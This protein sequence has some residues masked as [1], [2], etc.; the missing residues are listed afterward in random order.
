MNFNII[1]TNARSLRPKLSSFIDNFNELELSIAVVTETWFADGVRLDREA[2]DLLLGQNINLITRNRLIG[3]RGVAH[4]GVAVLGKASEVKLKELSFPNPEQF[5]VLPVQVTVANVEKKMFVIAVYIPPGYQV[6]RG[7]ACLQHINYLVLYIKNLPGDSNLCIAGDV[8]QWDIATALEDYPDLVEILTPPTRA[9]RNIDKIFTNWP[10]IK[11]T[12]MPPLET[13][14]LDGKKTKSDHLIQF[15]RAE[16]SRRE[17]HIWKKI[18]FRPFDKNSAANFKQDLATQ[19]WGRVFGAVGSNNKAR[20]FQTV[21]DVLMDTH[22]PKKTIRRKESDLPWFNEVAK[23]KAKRKK[24]VF[25]DEGKSERWI[26]LRDDLDGYLEGR[27]KKFLQ[28]QREG[29]TGGEASRQFFKLVKNYGTSEK[30]KTFDVRDLRP[31]KPDRDVA[32]EVAQYFNQISDEFSPLKPWEIPQTY[33]RDLPK[34]TPEMVEKR[35]HEMKKPNSM[36]EG[37]IFPKLVNECSGWLSVPLSD[38]YNCMLKTY[39]WP[40]AWKKEYVTVIPKKTLPTE[41]S[42]LRNISCTKFFSKVFESFLLQYAIEEVSTKDNQY[43]GKKG[44]STSHLLIE[45]WQNICENS[46]DYRAATA[47]AAI[48][49]SKAFNRLSFQ[50]CL[51]AFKRKGAS[52]TVIRLIA[53]FLTNRCMSVRVGDEWS[54]ELPVNGGCPQGSILGVFLFNMTTDDLEDDFLRAEDERLPEQDPTAPR[55]GGEG[56]EDINLPA[57]PLFLDESIQSTGQP[58]TSTPDREAPP[59]PE[60]DLSGIG[61][62]L[63]RHSDLIVHFNDYAKNIP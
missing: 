57:T 29:L 39:V 26:A 48:D 50:H 36:V 2:E 53:T 8:N 5:E 22:F 28:K 7:Q 16:L 1:N 32:D 63:Y 21:L 51:Q 17:P 3:P 35:L 27:Q 60:L 12:C 34:F 40:V 46:E 47:L 19:D 13:E 54:E 20:E 33:G 38:I 59:S 52:T 31:G 49:Y 30:P 11:A 61:R 45:V 18:T 23:R 24:A 25:R 10:V 55:V 9:G 62:N 4:G 42:E 37:D 41:F 43:G 14:E 44:H 58:E 15:V 6:A 56:E